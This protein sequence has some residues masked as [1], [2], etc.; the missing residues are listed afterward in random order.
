[1]ESDFFVSFVHIVRIL[2]SE[3]FVCH[4]RLCR[5]P[6]RKLRL[7]RR[8]LSCTYLEF[9]L[10]PLYLTTLPQLKLIDSPFQEEFTTAPD[11]QWPAN[12]EGVSTVRAV[13]PGAGNFAYF[14][15]QNAGHFVRCWLICDMK[16]RLIRS[17]FL[18][19]RW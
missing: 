6:G 4:I 19:Y 12:T 13:G 18:S 1:M 2:Y 17:N 8:F 5:C 10:R 7:A 11:L 15:V 16:Q 3:P 14:L 9:L